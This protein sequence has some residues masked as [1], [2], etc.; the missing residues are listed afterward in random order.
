MD[1]GRSHTTPKMELAVRI[2]AYETNND[3]LG[4]YR[5]RT[6]CNW[7][8]TYSLSGVFGQDSLEWT[9]SPIEETEEAE[10]DAAEN[11]RGNNE[12]V[13]SGDFIQTLSAD[14]SDRESLNKFNADPGVYV[15]VIKEDMQE[16]VKPS[17]SQEEENADA[18]AAEPE[19]E[20][21][22][23]PKAFLYLDPS[24]FLLTTDEP[25]RSCVKVCEGVYAEMELICADKILDLKELLPMEPLILSFDSVDGYP[26]SGAATRA[27]AMECMYISGTF[28]TGIGNDARLIYIRPS[29]TEEGSIDENGNYRVPLRFQLV[30]LPG[31]GN[32][33]NFREGLRSRT[34]TVEVHRED[35]FSRA[36]NEELVVKYHNVLVGDGEDKAD[37]LGQ[38][39]DLQDQLTPSYLRR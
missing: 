28:E 37:P 6:I 24:A 10:G 1:N 27:Q 38:P 20:L 21:H 22:L 8:S 34:Y 30:L 39:E 12:L 13:A 35:L 31:V 36:F 25:L 32:M 15:M 14:F 17:P 23:I 29:A 5:V 2:K 7:S 9:S 26:V 16:V 33:A 18:E 19:M 4:N 3:I 11:M